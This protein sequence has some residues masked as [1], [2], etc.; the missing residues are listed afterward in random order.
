MLFMIKEIVKDTTF[1]SQPCRTAT[2]KDLYIAKD[3]VDTLQIYRSRPDMQCWGIAANMIGYP[4]RMIIVH[5]GLEELVMVNPEILSRKGI[6]ESEEGCLS[7]PGVRTTKRYQEIVV[8]YRNTRY[9]WKK[10]RLSG[11]TAQV[12]Q[13]EMD[14]LE[15][16]LV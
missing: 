10:V 16:I 11:F 3:L 4:V 9:Q 14:H 5:N 8:K 12:V 13:H 7:L 2:K 15:G 1:L 6:Y